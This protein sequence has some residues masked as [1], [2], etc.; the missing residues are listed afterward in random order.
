MEQMKNLFDYAT[1]ELS[2][3]AFLAWLFANYDCEQEEVKW[4][5]RYILCSF[6]GVDYNEKGAS[7]RTLTVHKQKNNIDLYI[8]FEVEDKKYVLTIEDKIMSFNHD[9]QLVKYKEIIERDFTDRIKAFVY[10]KTSLIGKEEIGILQKYKGWN[11]YSV[12]EVFGLFEKFLQSND[13]TVYDNEIVNYYYNHLKGICDKIK[14][15][16]K[17][18][19]WG[20]IEWQSFFEEY[21]PIKGLM[22][23]T[24]IRC[25]RNEYVYI[26][27]ILEG[28]DKYN[29]I[30]PC[31]EI[32]SRDVKNNSLT[33][34]VVLYNTLEQYRT[35]EN[36]RNWQDKLR[37]KKIKLTNRKEKSKHK[38]IGTFD[39]AVE[40]NEESIKGALDKAGGI[41]ITLFK[42]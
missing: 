8:T 13:K 34:K 21:K 23:E 15:L 9:N 14:R 16:S 26:K 4:L 37:E 2:Q 29:T 12:E 36:I 35:E 30:V 10:Y 27:L 20:L 6:V 25:Y 32:R 3:D 24:E 17:P 1:K 11:P 22:E 31:L 38:Q 7:I 42:N 18:N 41:L 28:L 5:S 40:N 39:L 19:E 33:A